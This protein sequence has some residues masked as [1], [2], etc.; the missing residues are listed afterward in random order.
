M[1]RLKFY[2]FMEALFAIPANFF[3]DRADVIDPEFQKLL[4]QSMMLKDKFFIQR[5]EVTP[6]EGR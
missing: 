2:R 5:K 4:S 3:C 1:F 6:E